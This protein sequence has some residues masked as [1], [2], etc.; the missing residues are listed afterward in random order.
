MTPA[1]RQ[2]N[3]MERRLARAAA[4]MDEDGE[5]HGISADRVERIIDLVAQARDG[6]ITTRQMATRIGRVI[7]VK[8]E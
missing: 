1:E 8:F 5:L 2:A 3:Y 7:G 4:G 6:L